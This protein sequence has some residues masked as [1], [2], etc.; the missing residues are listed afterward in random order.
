MGAFYVCR[1]AAA[2]PASVRFPPFVSKARVMLHP[3]RPSAEGWE[4]PAAPAAFEVGLCVVDELF[5]LP[6]NTGRQHVRHD[7]HK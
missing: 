5:A 2:A 1:D 3:A 4:R 7:P 6:T